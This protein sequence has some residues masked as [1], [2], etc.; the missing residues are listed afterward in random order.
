[1]TGGEKVLVVGALGLGVFAY[2]KFRNVSQ[3][4]ISPPVPTSAS[5]NLVNSVLGLPGLRQAYLVLKPIA[6]NV[7]T[8]VINKLNSAVG[9][10]N[11]Y[12]P[13]A[14]VIDSKGNVTSKGVG[15][16]TITYKPGGG[17]T[18]SG[19]NSVGSKISKG[20]TGAIHAIESIF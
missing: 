2:L 18:I 19:G 12:G 4:K 10:P 15:G 8:P 9:G 13:P 6:D 14:V 17:V 11:V 5:P 20:A 3:S 7:T 16:T 1:M